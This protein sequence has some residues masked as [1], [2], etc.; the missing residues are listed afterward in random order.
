MGSLFENVEDGCEGL[1]GLCDGEEL[2]WGVGVK[3]VVCVVV[4]NDE[5]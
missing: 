5:L 3:G 1:V 2:C 4:C